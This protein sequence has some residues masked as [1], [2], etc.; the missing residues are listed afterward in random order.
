M[1]NIGKNVTKTTGNLF[2]FPV[3]PN[4]QW[5]GLLL[6]FS[7]LLNATWYTC[8]FSHPKKRFLLLTWPFWRDEK[9]S[10]YHVITIFQAI[11]ILQFVL[12]CCR[13]LSIIILVHR[14]L[15]FA[16]YFK[17]DILSSSNIINNNLN[18]FSLFLLLFALEY[19]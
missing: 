6:A 9:F 17:M 2:T 14:S 4:P 10:F 7:R 11:I 18:S 1:K 12:I 13:I 19:L 3:T 5:K 8:V 15:K 16:C